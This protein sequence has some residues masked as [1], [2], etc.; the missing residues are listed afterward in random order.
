MFEPYNFKLEK[1]NIYYAGIIKY[2]TVYLILKTDNKQF[3]ES[4]FLGKVRFIK[5]K[6]SQIVPGNDKDPGP[7]RF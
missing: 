2:S 6:K 7:I 5:S 1:A 3:F 4:I